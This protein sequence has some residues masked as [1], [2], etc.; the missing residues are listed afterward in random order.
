MIIA[1]PIIDINPYLVT[2]NI[3]TAII[4]ILLGFVQC[5]YGLRIFRASI[6]ILFSIFIFSLVLLFIYEILLPNNSERY[7]FWICFGSSV[8]MG[9]IFSYF[10]SYFISENK[11]KISLLIGLIFGWSISQL[12][13]FGISN[14]LYFYI[15]LGLIII[16]FGCIS[17]TKYEGSLIFYTS[18][19]GSYLFVRVKN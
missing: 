19:L 18:T 15:G 7:L 3:I 16:L 14:K 6:F 11:R 17:F 2:I 8:L 4:F 13:L 9:I 1:C 12:F 5:I 10:I